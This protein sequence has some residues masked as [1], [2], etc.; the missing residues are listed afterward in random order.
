MTRASRPETLHT[1]LG[2]RDAQAALNWLEK[3]FGFQTLFAFPDESGA[4][5][6]AEMTYGDASFVVFADV[7]GYDRPQPKGDTVGQGAYL[8]VPDTETVDAIFASGVAAGGTVVWEPAWTEWGNYRCRFRDPE[9]REWTFG[10]HRPGI[11]QEG[12]DWSEDGA[13]A[14]GPGTDTASVGANS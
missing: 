6:H 14:G 5:Q 10:V 4:I 1:Y 8:C 7:D 13:S 12:G 11:P 9:G 2:Y 3:A